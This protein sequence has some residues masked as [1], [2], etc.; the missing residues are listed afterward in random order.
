MSLL[1][2]YSL[3]TRFIKFVM[4]TY[5]FNCLSEIINSIVKNVFLG[6]HR[7]VRQDHCALNT[8]PTVSNHIDY[9]RVSCFLTLVPA[10]TSRFESQ[11]L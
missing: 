1:C 7:S 5:F 10:A 9:I 4:A 2:K 11:N 8:D 3:G 6:F